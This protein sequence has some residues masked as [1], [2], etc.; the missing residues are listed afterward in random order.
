M[1]QLVSR[2]VNRL[3]TLVNRLMDSSRAEA[4]RMEGSFSPH[5]LGALTADLASLFRAAIEK[6]RIDYV[7]E[8]DATDPRLVYGSFAPPR[9]LL[10][11]LADVNLHLIILQLM[12]LCGRRSVLSQ[13]EL[14]VLVFDLTRLPPSFRSSST[15]SETPSSTASRARSGSSSL[16]ERTRSSLEFRM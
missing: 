8:C 7:V 2:N 12:F 10:R 5:Q 15:S 6:E 9:S 16:I 13:V 11:L 4:G 1:L 3:R 14:F